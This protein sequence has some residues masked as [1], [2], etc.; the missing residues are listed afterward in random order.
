MGGYID[1]LGGHGK[2]DEFFQ[3]LRNG[4]IFQKWGLYIYVGDRGAVEAP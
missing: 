4:K 1:Y 3:N 2:R